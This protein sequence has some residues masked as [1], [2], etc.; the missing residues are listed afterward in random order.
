MV[1]QARPL[2]Q[3]QDME[4]SRSVASSVGRNAT[5]SRFLR[6]RRPSL[7]REGLRPA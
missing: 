1:P 5:F 3:E 6:V 2:A 4:S 7:G